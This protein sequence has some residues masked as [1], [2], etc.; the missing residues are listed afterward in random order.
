MQGGAGQLVEGWDEE[1]GG[2]GAAGGVFDGDVWVGGRIERSVSRSSDG[3]GRLH[4]SSHSGHLIL[5]RHRHGRT[6]PPGCSGSV[7][8]CLL[9]R[10]TRLDGGIN[11]LILLRVHG[12][13]GRSGPVWHPLFRRYTRL[14]SCPGPLVLLLGSAGYQGV[15]RHDDASLFVPLRVNQYPA[16][17]HLVE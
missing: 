6:S 5:R 9:R 4:G 14:D 10:Y 1:G 2:A 17:K 16:E 8:S 13:L 7:Q 12:H 15:G 3:S 11:C